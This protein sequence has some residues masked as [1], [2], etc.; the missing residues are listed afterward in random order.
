[1]KTLLIN[2]IDGDDGQ[3]KSFYINPQHWVSITKREDKV[4]LDGEEFDWFDI[5]MTDGR[6]IKQVTF[7]HEEI[8]RGIGKAYK[9][10]Y[11]PDY[12]EINME[13]E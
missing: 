3:E 1:M 8:M 4:S 5:E 13:D 2:T 12:H 7:I 10:K 11:L 6:I 9:E